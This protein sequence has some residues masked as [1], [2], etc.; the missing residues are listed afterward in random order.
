M[1][2]RLEVAAQLRLGEKSTRQALD[3]VCLAQLAH[4]SLERL[5]AF[6]FG[7]GRSWTLAG[8]AF[9]LA[10]PAARSGVQPILAAIDPIAAHCEQYSL[11][12]SLTMRAALD[13]FGGILGLLLHDSFLSNNL[14]LLQNSGRFSRIATTR[15][16]TKFRS[17]FA[18]YQYKASL[19]EYAYCYANELPRRFGTLA[20]A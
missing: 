13:D 9:L 19:I 11:A 5:D 18:T 4:L 6:F 8:I 16:K 15:R 1:P 7:G 3:L 2:S 17:R 14:E 10:Y 20:N 12:A